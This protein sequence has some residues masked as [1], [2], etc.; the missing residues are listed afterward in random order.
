MR[1]ESNPNLTI[2][3]LL[4]SP[5]DEDP[6]SQKLAH[7]GDVAGVVDVIPVYAWFEEGN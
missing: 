2:Q 1:K 5:I 3:Y 6:K 4:L 7:E